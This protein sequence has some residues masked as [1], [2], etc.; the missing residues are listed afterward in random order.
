MALGS[1]WCSVSEVVCIPQEGAVSDPF[2]SPDLCMPSSGMSLLTWS[3][4]QSLKQIVSKSKG[5]SVCLCMCMCVCV[6]VCVTPKSHLFS[7]SSTFTITVCQGCSGV[8]SL[9]I[10]VLEALE[11][12]L[13]RCRPEVDTQTHGS[14]TQGC[15][16]AWTLLSCAFGA[17]Q[18][19]STTLP[20]GSISTHPVPSSPPIL[21]LLLLHLLLL[22]SSRPQG[23]AERI[24]L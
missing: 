23:A 15:G 9:V 19:P 7:G 17:C 20:T 3:E 18:L 22:L 6:Y 24:P 21:L 12:L 11:L 4:L 2:S 5:V 10:P 16:P 13:L 14:D 1:L 8:L